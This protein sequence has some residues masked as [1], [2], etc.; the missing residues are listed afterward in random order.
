MSSAPKHAS[1]IVPVPD[2]RTMKPPSPPIR[3]LRPPHLA[4]MAIVRARGDPAAARDQQAVAVA[5]LEREGV[6]QQVRGDV[7]PAALGGCRVGRDEERLAAEHLALEALHDAAVDAGREHHARRVRD[8]RVRLHLEHLAARERAAGNGVGRAV[9]DRDLHGR[10][11]GARASGASLPETSMAATAGRSSSAERRSRGSASSQSAVASRET[12]ASGR[13]RA[14]ER[15]G[16]PGRR[17]DLQRRADAEAAAGALD[18]RGGA[19]PGRAG[20][21]LAEE[22]DLRAQRPAALEALG[23]QPRLGIAL[24]RGRHVLLGAAAQAARGAQVAVHLDGVAAGG[25]V[26][27]VDVLRHDAGDEARPASRRASAACAGLCTM[28]APTSGSAQH[29]QTRAGIAREHVDV[30][31]DHRIEPLPEAAGRAEVGQAAGGRDARAGEREH[32]RVALEEA[33]ERAASGSA[34]VHAVR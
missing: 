3:F 14:G 33:R 27:A 17:V 30:P 23:R 18:E 10:P 20:Q 28:R 34:A 19:A 6:A 1:T 4:S 21:R 11:P 16:Q 8:H 9:T 31:V 2:A 12:I 13:P 7:D 32:G 25:V 15:L 26:Q 24:E 5:H 22:H 29:C